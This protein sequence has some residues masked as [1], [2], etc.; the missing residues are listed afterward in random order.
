[1]AS[2]AA[3]TLGAAAVMR[4]EKAVRRACA[5]KG[6]VS[7]VCKGCDGGVNELKPGGHEGREGGPQG[8]CSRR[9][10]FEHMQEGRRAIMVSMA[11]VRRR[12]VGHKCSKRQGFKHMQG[13]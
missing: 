8:L 5:A 9:K 4:A 13:K 11:A 3:V 7:S 12:F 6:R 10:D 1:M 2:M